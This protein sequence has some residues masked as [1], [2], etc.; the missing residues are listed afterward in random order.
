M[1]PIV[2]S[3]L[4]HAAASAG[5]LS[6]TANFALQGLDQTTSMFRSDSLL[7][8]HSWSRASQQTVLIN[9]DDV[10]FTKNSLRFGVNLYRQHSSGT[11]EQFRP[12]YSLDLRS[13]GYFMSTSYSP[14][15]LSSGV[16]SN[17]VKRS[18]VYY[19]D[20]R[21]NISINY[22]QYPSVSFIHNE[23]KVFDRENPR[24]YD[25]KGTT[26]V[27]ESSYSHG[28]LSIRGNYNRLVQRNLIAPGDVFKNNAYT[29]ALAYN[30][31]IHSVGYATA[32]YSYYD[33]RTTRSALENPVPVLVRTHAV[34]L[35][36]SSREYAGLSLTSSYSGRFSD[37][38][39]QTGRAHSHDE[40]ASGQLS[41]VPFKFLEFSAL[42]A[43]QKSY[44]AGLNQIT[45]YA[46]L[47]STFTRFLHHGLDTRITANKTW[48]QRSAQKSPD[49]VKGAYSLDTYY[50]SLAFVPIGYL[51]ALADLSISRNNR[52]LV[53]N[54]RFQ[55]SRS[56]NAQLFFSRRLEGRV[57]A[58]WLDQS[59]QLRVNNSYSVSYNAGLTYYP[60]GNMNM[61]LSYL[62]TVNRTGTTSKTDMLAGFASYSFRRAFSVYVSANRQEQETDDPMFPGNRVNVRPYNINASLQIYPS[63]R[64]TVTVGYLYNRTPTT[65]TLRSIGKQYSLNV[66]IQ[67]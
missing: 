20:W 62:R 57:S 6:G 49:N 15:H 47:S 45:E 65:Q 27:L 41:Y 29:G 28:P 12:I 44:E 58:L 25:S 11:A 55:I 8:E 60:R 32:T 54:Q 31:D 17:G 61:N 56:I 21:S 22:P 5:R 16:D 33:S 10:L 66:N 30:Q 23:S 19:R 51:K 14:Y 18:D 38:R 53:A 26:T 43:Y 42:K 2:A 50:G 34:N 37:N 52:P 59:A 46:T 64:S 67:F 48:F 39:L 1:A 4:L 3:I 9:Y 40:T 24:R 13:Q 35:L 36:Y 63:S 7:D